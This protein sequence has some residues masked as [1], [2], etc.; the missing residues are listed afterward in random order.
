MDLAIG[1]RDNPQAMS[2]ILT[3]SACMLSWVMAGWNSFSTCKLSGLGFG[4]VISLR[5]WIG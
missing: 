5:P 1:C 3:S 4:E 2:E